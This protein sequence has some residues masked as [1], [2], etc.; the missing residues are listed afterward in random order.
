[1]SSV[2]PEID[3]EIDA[4]DLPARAVAPAELGPPSVVVNDLHVTYRVIGARRRATPLAK[5][6]ALR[7]LLAKGGQ[8]TGAVTEVKAV[9][10]VSF[11]AHHG[12]SIGIIGTNGSGKSTLLQAVAGL[13]PVTSGSVY[14]SGTPSLLG[15]NAALIKKVSG[16]RNILIG[17]LALGL[18]R[19][20]IEAR[21]DEIVDFAGIG[22]FVELP[23]NTYSSGMAARLRFAISTAAV[24]DVLMID[25]ALATGDAAFRKRSKQRI[26]QIRHDAGTVFFVSHS[27]AS[28][29]AMCTRA[30]WLDKGVIRAD[31]PVDEVADLYAAYVAELHSEGKDDR[32][33][34]Q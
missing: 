27:L 34:A 22:D 26:E 12:E 6:S 21:F 4:E 25:E 13:L 1:M 9:R 5:Q 8:H 20:E 17:G 19:A 2:E 24:P 14:L 31:G 33:D 29:R 28:V 30:I 23:M 16:E 3:F 7:R 32:D 10:G 11:V 18:S 15:V